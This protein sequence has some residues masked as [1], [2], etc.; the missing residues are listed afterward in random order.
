MNVKMDLHFFLKENTVLTSKV[1]TFLDE[2]KN[3][4][5]RYNCIESLILIGSLSRNEGSF[6]E[7]DG[8]Y[9]ITSDAEFL[10]ILRDRKSIIDS[11]FFDEVE[12]IK[13]NTFQSESKLFHVD[14]TLL[15]IHQL[16]KLQRIFLVFEAKAFG[17]TIYGENVLHKIPAINYNNICVLDINDIL[18]HRLFSVI[19]Y[20]IHNSNGLRVDEITYIFSKN[21]LDML[22]LELFQKGILLPGFTNRI[23]LIQTNDLLVDDYRRMV[24]LKSY[25]IKTGNSIQ[26]E[27]TK[28]LLSSFMNVASG[29]YKNIHTSYYDMLITNPVFY[30][31]RCLGVVKR[32]FRKYVYG[33]S[34]KK[35]FNNMANFIYEYINTNKVNES[36]YNK[37]LF[38]HFCLFNFPSNVA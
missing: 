27:D 6:I 9:L 4:C 18:L 2:I 33:V 13:S 22:S 21:I 5:I 11:K 37:I 24:Y 20:G 19:Y 35:H 28:N 3:I 29:L 38:E 25:Q 15:S 12:K 31:R 8:S 36:L 16:K 32:G 30:L 7:A 14:F 26:N 34:F 23:N 1:N 10:L 17:K